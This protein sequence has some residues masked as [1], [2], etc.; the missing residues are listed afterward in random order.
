M[1]SESLFPYVKHKI[2]GNELNINV[3]VPHNGEYVLQIHARDTYSESYENVC[4]YLLTSEDTKR[5]KLRS[6][7]VCKF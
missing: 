3:G 1:S 4:N 7:Q 2:L 6:Y 5:E